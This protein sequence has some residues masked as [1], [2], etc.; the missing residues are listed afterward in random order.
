MMCLILHLIIDR[1]NWDYLTLNKARDA[2]FNGSY[3]F[4][5]SV[6]PVK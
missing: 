2:F 1:F 4:L 3:L 5:D 6:C